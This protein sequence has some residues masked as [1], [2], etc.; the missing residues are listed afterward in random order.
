MKASNVW[1]VKASVKSKAFASKRRGDMFINTPFY[2]R[3]WETGD[4]LGRY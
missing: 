1:I 4:H 3:K 2:L